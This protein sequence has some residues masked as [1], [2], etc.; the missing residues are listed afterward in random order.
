MSHGDQGARA[1]IAEVADAGSVPAARRGA[2][3][4]STPK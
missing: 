4:A 3:S 1:I 2:L